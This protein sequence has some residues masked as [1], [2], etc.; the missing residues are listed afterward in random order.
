MKEVSRVGFLGVLGNVFLMLIKLSS[1]IIFASQAMLADGMNSAMDIFASLM[2]LLGGRIAEKPRDDDHHFGH[3]KAEFLFALLVSL[4]MFLGAFLIFLEAFQGLFSG[5]QLEF[6]YLLIFVCVITILTKGLLYCYSRK[7]FAETKSI[8]VESN[9]IDHR[10]DMAVTTFTLLS[11]LLSRFS[12][13]FFDSLTGM[14]IAFWIGYSGIKIF[15]DSYTILMD[16]ALDQSRVDVIKTYI[17]RNKKIQGISKFETTPVGYQYLLILSILV[18][19][20]LSTFE[21]HAIADLL[22]KKLLKKFPELLT[23]TIHVN[24]MDEKK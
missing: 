10:N 20:N 18:D 2:T 5:H 3:G 8:L 9:M 22:E 21:S 1:G 16:H 15:L 12:L 4:S 24:P 23:V 11:I 19:G 13:S 14:G 7:V 17:L 6:S